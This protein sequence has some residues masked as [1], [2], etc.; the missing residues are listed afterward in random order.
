MMQHLH[1]ELVDMARAENFAPVTV[2][3]ERDTELLGRGAAYFGWQAQDLHLAGASGN[4]AKATAE[5]GKELVERAASG[6]VKLVEEIGNYPLS[7]LR[8]RTAFD[9]A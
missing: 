1:P 8:T 2:E 9:G 3:I 5:L 7:R 6:L 4:A